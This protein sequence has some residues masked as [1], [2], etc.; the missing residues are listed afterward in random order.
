MRRTATLV[1]CAI[2]L[3]CLVMLAQFHLRAIVASS[4]Q[5]DDAHN[6]NVAK[7]LAFGKGY[8]TSY[9]EL[10]RF[11]PE[12]TTGPVVLM[13]A[14][15]FVWLFG[16]QYWVPT[17]AVVVCLWTSLGVV[18]LLLRRY[19]EPPAWWITIALI[20]FGLALYDA[21]EFGL[22]GDVPGALLAVASVLALCRQNMRGRIWRAGLLLGI[23]I[24]IKL[25]VL[26]V[27]PAA[28]AYILLAPSSNRRNDLVL[29]C[30]AVIL[31]SVVW[32]LYQLVS[33]GSFHEWAA[34]N[35][36]QFAFIRT[37]SGVNIVQTMDVTAA[38]R[39][40]VVL[41]VSSLLEDFHGWAPLLLFPAALVVSV[42]V[43]WQANRLDDA[44]LRSA[45][46]VL[47]A[48]GIIHLVWWFTLDTDGWFRHLLPAVVYVLVAVSMA[49]AANATTSPRLGAIGLCLLLASA[50]PQLSNLNY[51][52]RPFR[53]EPRLSALLATRDAMIRL[54]RNHD[55]VFVG[56]GWW[57][58]RDLEYVLPTV[59]N[60]KDVLRLRKADVAG[61]TVVLVRNE[62]FNREHSPYTSAFQR[63]CDRNTLFTREP[64]VIS[65]CT[66]LPGDL[67]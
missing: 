17:F 31:P 8:S 10:V 43:L 44:P 42:G 56:Y 28:L 65:A 33:I 4:I 1:P 51:V 21:D 46:F 23:A 3:A 49:A 12:A 25:L 53:P 37:W 13:P 55:F 54:Q 30:S 14:A 5:Y 7:D 35:A 19:L 48:A 64:F 62:F 39:R 58:P 2:A 63:A 11:N 36:R 52:F 61:K 50:I 29:F 38:A 15:G 20:A 24:Q 26:L 32:E 40:Q 41:H 22:L 9:H 45:S 27:A 60:F 57:V 66:S 16:N 67:R 59:G 18:L 47:I 6:A 34:L